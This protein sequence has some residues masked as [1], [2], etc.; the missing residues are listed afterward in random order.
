MNNILDLKNKIGG[1]KPISCDEAQRIIGLIENGNK[2]QVTPQ[3]LAAVL[4]HVAECD[5]CEVPTS[6][7]DSSE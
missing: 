2:D 5:K 4:L 1:Y 7:T 3:E 6:S